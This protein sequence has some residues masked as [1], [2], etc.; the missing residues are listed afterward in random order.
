MA[1]FTPGLSYEDIT[2]LDDFEIP[3]RLL[4][5]DKEWKSVRVK[6]PK[7]S[8]PRH[9]KP[10][11]STNNSGHFLP[12]PFANYEFRFACEICYVKHNEGK[13]GCEL[14][15]EFKHN[16]QQKYLLVR[17][18]NQQSAQNNNAAWLKIRP[19]PVNMRDVCKLAHSHQS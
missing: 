17:N 12:A 5:E 7:K 10:A 19:R 13:G 9:T 18:I 6:S 4:N 11:A 3:T 15:R 2:V 14:K 1:S 16:C 8:P